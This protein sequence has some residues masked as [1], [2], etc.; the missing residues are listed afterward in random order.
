[1]HITGRTAPTD[2]GSTPAPPPTSATPATPPSPATPPT[3]ATPATADHRTVWVGLGVTVAETIALAVA[4]RATGSTA[5]LTQTATSLA[6][7]AGSVFLLI[8]VISSRRVADQR[9]PL[10]YGRERFFWSLLAA[11]GVFVG[12]FGVALA[13]TVHAWTDPRPPG[14]FLVG[15]TVLGVVLALDGVG[16]SAGLRPLLRRAA[17]RELSVV[18][19]L[20]RGTD[21]AATTVVLTNAAGVSGGVLAGGGLAVSHLTG[22]PVGDTVAGALIGI[23]LLATSIIL[24]HTNR[25]LL[26][27]RGLPL[28]EITRMRDVVRQQAGVEAVPDLFAVFVGPATLMVDGDVIFEDALDVPAVEA[29]IV[30][31]AAALRQDW[32]AI[33][34]VYLN[35]VA[36]PRARRHGGTAP[37][38]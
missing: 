13:E 34:Y 7:V 1:M 10:G 14:S 12:G 32:P 19:L 35:P 15:Y 33:A 38:G 2:A 16:L 20:W 31:A 8:G 6:D 18:G 37:A 25:E 5:L 11:V 28:A 21:P 30:T 27:G 29:A 26:T 23:V 24:L 17:D 3:P 22:S 36:T 9:H 4:A